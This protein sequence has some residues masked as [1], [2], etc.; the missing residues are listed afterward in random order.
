MVRI[1]VR[2]KTDNRRGSLGLKSTLVSL[3]TNHCGME[4][5]RQICPLVRSGSLALA[6]GDESRL[7]KGRVLFF[8]A[9][10]TPGILGLPSPLKH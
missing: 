5:G 10:G 8:M 1:V 2:K 4:L 7:T 6:P 3:V 9:W